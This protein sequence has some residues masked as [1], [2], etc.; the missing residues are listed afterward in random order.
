[1]PLSGY[2]QSPTPRLRPA[3]DMFDNA[4]GHERICVLGVWEVLS[5]EVQGLSSI[6]SQRAVWSLR[7]HKPTRFQSL[8]LA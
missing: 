4:D 7:I 2:C 8:L 6:Y 5:R 3:E 1:M